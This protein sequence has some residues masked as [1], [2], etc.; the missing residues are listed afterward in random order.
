[1]RIGMG[2][3]YHARGGMASRAG[4]RERSPVGWP[5]SDKA[6]LFGWRRSGLLMLDRDFAHRGNFA[7][8]AFEPW[9]EEPMK[10]LPVIRLDNEKQSMFGIGTIPADQFDPFDVGI[11]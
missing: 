10:R 1:M 5:R 4:E 6:L 11:E 2:G 8:G 7:G 3:F 9:Q